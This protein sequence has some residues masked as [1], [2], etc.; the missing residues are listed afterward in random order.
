MDERTKKREG[1]RSRA[2]VRRAPYAGPVDAD[3]CRGVLRRF[4]DDV[5]NRWD[6]DVLDEMVTEDVR[7]RGSLGPTFEGRDELRGY[8]RGLRD[9][10]PDLSV[11][12]EQ[13]VAE[14]DA[15]AARLTFR[16]THTGEL[17]GIAGSGQHVSWSAAALFRFREG[18]IS[19]LWSVGDTSALRRQIA[20]PAGTV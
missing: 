1:G 9:A 8:M 17:M 13:M 19:D 7:F 12:V 5:W 14:T 6:L 4:Y 20:G 16:G 2:A 3:A 15:A 18:R 11:V 10:M